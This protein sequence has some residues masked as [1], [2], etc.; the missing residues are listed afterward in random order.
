MFARECFQ[1]DGMRGFEYKAK[2]RTFN[3]GARKKVIDI[4]KEGFKVTGYVCM[5]V[6]VLARVCMYLEFRILVN[7]HCRIVRFNERFTIFAYIIFSTFY[8]LINWFISVLFF[9][10]YQTLKITK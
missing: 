8:Y 4:N 9:L 7:I 6:C 10:Y 1:Y 3:M 2:R 5:W